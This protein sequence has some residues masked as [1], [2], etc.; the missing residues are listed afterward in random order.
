MLLHDHRQRLAFGVLE[1]FEEHALGALALD[2][3]ARGLEV[4]HDRCQVVVVGTFAHH[5]GHG[6][7]DVEQLVGFLA[8]RQ[9]DVLEAR[10]QRQALRIAGLQLD[11]Q[12]P[13]AGGEFLGLVEAFLRGAVE[14]FQV[15]QRFAG[16]R[17]FLQVGQ[18]HAELGAP[19]AH[20]VLA[21]HRVAEELEH[22][23]DAVTDDGRTQVADV[24]LFGQVGRR[25]VDDHLFGGAGFAYA[26][27]VVGQ[28]RVQALGQGVSVLEEVEEPGTG[29]LDFADVGAGRQRRDQ[30]VGEV[31]RLH[32]RRLGQ[33]HGDVAGEVAMGLV[34]GVLHLNRWRQPFR[35][36]TVGDELGE[37]LLD[38]LAN[39]VFHRVLVS[40][41]NAASASMRR[42]KNWTLSVLEP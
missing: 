13:G 38:Q 18:Q 36:H 26:Q 40:T 22:A 39:G 1:L 24:H 21:D 3:Q 14:V 30:L 10:P 7:F 28:R 12:A 8:V 2:Q 29:D 19:V 35:Q 41:A 5:V 27:V 25:Q 16:D 34:A 37:S 31:A 23:G 4:G 6:Q 42:W 11:H 15:R 17:V 32:A 20:V 9:R 33:H